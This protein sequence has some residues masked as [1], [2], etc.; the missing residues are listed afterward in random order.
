MPHIA[1]NRQFVNNIRRGEIM[2]NFEWDTGLETNYKKIDNQHKELFTHLNS[3][4]DASRKGLGNDEI[5]KVLDFLTEYTIMHFKTEED[6][7]IAFKYGDYL[8]HKKCHDDFKLTVNQLSN[9]LNEE[10]PSPELIGSVSKT[11]AEWLVLHIKQVDFRM[12]AFVRTK[13]GG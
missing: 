9:R 12:A 8:S 13:D 2:V 6:L 11:I 7:M 4:I 5:F 3:L 10:G 1:K